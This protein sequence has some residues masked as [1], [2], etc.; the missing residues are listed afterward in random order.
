VRVDLDMARV[1]AF[2]V[3]ADEM[4]FGRAAGRLFLSQQALSKRI[5]RLEEEL[6][7]RLFTRDKHVELTQAGRRFLEPARHA[8]AAAEAAAAAARDAV[9]PLR[10]DVWGHAY[11]P[12]R[13]LGA[14]VGDAPAL[15]AEVSHSRDLPSV[16]TALTRDETDAGFGR[17]HPI[18]GRTHAGFAHRIVRLEPVD[19]VFGPH[20]PL[21]DARQ[22]HPSD[23]RDSLLWAPAALNRLDFLA[24][25][26]EEFGISAGHEG[27]NLGL[28]HFL[29][30]IL[31]DPRRFSLLPADL[32]LPDHPGVRS[33]PITGPT[34]LYA[35]SLIWHEERD[36]SLLAAL[37]RAADRAGRQRRW[38]DFDP[39]HDWLPD[40]DRAQLQR[41][42]QADSRP[43]GASL[44]TSER[45][46]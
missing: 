1:R 28:D 45:V 40:H 27:A 15:P 30:Q 4:H 18:R 17:V 9:G 6:G 29:G 21:A 16:L 43:G 31:A 2:V 41:Q 24:G 36:H 23:L 19:A 7:V 44:R 37:L 10:I 12:M 33:V 46:R 13:T 42:L 3:T 20:H 25:F 34:P 26:A 35:W 38:L 32:D 5:V 11:G 22:V 39:A 14:L 8:M